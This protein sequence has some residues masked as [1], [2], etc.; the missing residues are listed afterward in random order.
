[1]TT[2]LTDVAIQ[3]NSQLIKNEELTK[4][5][6]HLRLNLRDEYGLK[7]PKVIK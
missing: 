7:I 3:V 1:L 4:Q 6:N 2:R 5:V